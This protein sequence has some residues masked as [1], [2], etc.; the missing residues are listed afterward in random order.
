MSATEWRAPSKRLLRSLHRC[1]QDRRLGAL[2]GASLGWTSTWIGFPA[3]ALA[4]AI[5]SQWRAKRPPAVIGGVALLVLPAL[6]SLSA[7]FS[8]GNLTL[9]SASLPRW[10]GKDDGRGPILSRNWT[11]LTDDPRLQAFLQKNRGTARYLLAAPNALLAA[12]VIIATGQPV[13]AFGGFFGNDPVMSVDAFARAVERGSGGSERHSAG[14]TIVPC[15]R[16]QRSKSRVRR[17]V[18]STT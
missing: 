12:P 14:S 6:W 7:V 3:V 8:P 18:A 11:A 10:L 17:L 5:A 15:V 2:A 9:P 4:A 16:T 1:R 13:M